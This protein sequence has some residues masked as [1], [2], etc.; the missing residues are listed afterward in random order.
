RNDSKPASSLNEVKDLSE[1][2]RNPKLET[3]TLLDPDEYPVVERECLAVVVEPLFLP[4]HQLAAGVAAFEPHDVFG[5]AQHRGRLLFAHADDGLF[6][7]RGFLDVL[8]PLL[9][10]DI[11][12][13]LLLVG[14]HFR[15]LRLG[16]ALGIERGKRAVEPLHEGGDRD[17]TFLAGREGDAVK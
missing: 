1:L 5:L 11:V 4:P 8:G 6:P 2:S 15:A 9:L 16:V 7:E 3:E 10:A 12:A 13:P 14:G 17:E